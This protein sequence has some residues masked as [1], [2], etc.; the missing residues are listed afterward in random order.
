MLRKGCSRVADETKWNET[1]F[2]RHSIPWVALRPSNGTW[3]E[4]LLCNKHADFKCG[5]YI[6]IHW[7]KAG[8]GKIAEFRPSDVHPS[9]PRTEPSLYYRQ[10]KHQRMHSQPQS[11]RTMKLQWKMSSHPSTVDKHDGLQSGSKIVRSSVRNYVRSENVCL[12]EELCPRP[13]QARCM[14]C[15]SAR[16]GL[17]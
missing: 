3:D 8:S 9:R 15:T 1:K 11:S 5:F 17:K 6:S 12:K 16:I 7:W 4:T 2:M 14:G 10:F 13:H